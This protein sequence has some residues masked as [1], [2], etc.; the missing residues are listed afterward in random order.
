MKC[1][2]VEGFCIEVKID[3]DTAVITANREGLRS[4][5]TICSMLAEQTN[6]SHIHLDECNSLEKASAE[7]II[8][9]NTG[10]GK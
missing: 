10:L 1:E 6:G 4:L 2:W 5:S 3:G 8:S 7:L 9:V